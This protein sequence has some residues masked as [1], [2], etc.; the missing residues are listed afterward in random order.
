MACEDCKKKKRKRDDAERD[1]TIAAAG[2]TALLALVL[3]CYALVRIDALRKVVA[4][5]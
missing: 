3:V 4:E 2:V 1:D 5:R